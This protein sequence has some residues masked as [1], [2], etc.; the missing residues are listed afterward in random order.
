M[1]EKRQLRKRDRVG[2]LFERN[3]RATSLAEGLPVA[4]YLVSAIHALKG[5]EGHARRAAGRC[6]KSNLVVA[7]GLVGGISGG[8]AGIAAGAA[9]GS[10]AG[11]LAERGVNHFIEDREVR[12]DLG[13][14]A[15]LAENPAREL[16]KTAGVTALD[17]AL[18]AL[19]GKMDAGADKVI[20][21]T[22]NK[23]MT[24]AVA[25]GSTTAVKKA[26]KSG[27]KMAGKKA[28]DALAEEA[29][30]CMLDSEAK[31]VSTAIKDIGQLSVEVARQPT[32]KVPTLK[33]LASQV[34]LRGKM[35]EELCLNLNEIAT[36]LKEFGEVEEARQSTESIPPLKCLGSQIPMANVSDDNTENEREMAEQPQN[37]KFLASQIPQIPQDGAEDFGSES[38]GNEFLSTAEEH[39]ESITCLG[40][41]IP[42]AKAADDN[43]EN[44]GEMAEQTQN[45]KFLASQ[46]P[47]IP[48]DVRDGIAREN[49]AFST[50]EE[51][52]EE[53][54]CLG[55]QIP[56]R[57]IAYHHQTE[58]VDEPEESQTKIVGRE[59][60]S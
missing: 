46:I 45:L 40:S 41:Q 35:P 10:L 53:V 15:D 50:A 52:P 55:S 5:N 13:S 8:T 7:G 6:T 54:K 30:N 4:G 49:E 21:A 28:T 26:V 24:R 17:G 44:E 12:S 34:P 47:K 39:M 37:L 20:M 31:N 56:Q 9:V 3:G 19:G 2:R 57:E 29:G 51:H 42:R 43:A 22:A 38:I 14:L 11:Q 27:L 18:G 60:N 33:F 25:K 36:A 58:S 23:K 59:E 48:Q 1:V 32:E 16:V